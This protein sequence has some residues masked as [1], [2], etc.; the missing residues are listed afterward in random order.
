MPLLLPRRYG[1]WKSKVMCDNGMFISGG[2]M[3]VEPSQGG[4]DDTAANGLKIFCTDP[5]KPNERS[6][7]KTVW[8]G[9]WGDW[10]RQRFQVRGVVCE[11]AARVESRQGGGDD[12]A[13]NGLKFKMCDFPGAAVAAIKGRWRGPLATSAD[14]KF[15]T[16]IDRVNEVTTVEEQKKQLTA[17][18]TA[19]FSKG[20]FTGVGTV[21]Y[22]LADTMRTTVRDVMSMSTTVEC[23]N[24]CSND[25]YMWQ[26][27][28][29]IWSATGYL[30]TSVLTCN[31]YC[32]DYQET[33]RCHLMSCRDKGR[34]QQCCTDSSGSQ[35]FCGGPTAP[36]G[37]PLPSGGSSTTRC[38]TSWTD[39]N[40]KCGTAC[41]TNAECTGRET[42]FAHLAAC[43]TS[44]SPRRTSN[45]GTVRCGTSWANANGKCGTSCPGGVDSEC[46]AGERCFASLAVC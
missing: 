37:S 34:C 22:E 20:S 27:M 29:E 4:G 8:N 5:M 11:A 32:M 1:D 44:P 38:G 6:G 16:R 28:V 13:L 40:G 17:E 30:L 2:Q 21:S 31:V 23:P 3:R 19:T 7:W 18:V 43:G 33:P 46:P 36:S 35:T 24:K 26:E 9:Y 10:Q 41:V 39:A 14:T 15:I 12:T 42:C 45:G 25:Q